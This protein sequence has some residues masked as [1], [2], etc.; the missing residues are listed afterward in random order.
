MKKILELEDKLG[1]FA[2]LHRIKK[3]ASLTGVITEGL[4]QECRALL[5][6][7]GQQRISLL[8][9]ADTSDKE[10]LNVAAQEM[11]KREMEWADGEGLDFSGRFEIIIINAGMLGPEL[12]IFEPPANTCK[13]LKGRQSELKDALVHHQRRYFPSLGR[14][15]ISGRR[16]PVKLKRSELLEPQICGSGFVDKVAGGAELL[17]GRTDLFTQW[18]ASAA[19]SVCSTEQSEGLASQL[20][21]GGIAPPNPS[22]LI[23]SSIPDRVDGDATL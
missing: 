13:V 16:E 12:Q 7:N 4:L 14:D 18:T 8:I 5:T 17:D 10:A 20:S 2:E 3:G 11:V 21:G 15:T 22:R 6:A 23:Y 1:L 19:L 9:A